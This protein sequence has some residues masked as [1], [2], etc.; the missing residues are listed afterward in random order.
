[1]F[2]DEIKGSIKDVGGAMQR[3]RSE[4]AGDTDAQVARA[5][6]DNPASDLVS[7]RLCFALVFN[8]IFAMI[9]NPHRLQVAEHGGIFA[10]SI[11]HRGDWDHE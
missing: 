7:V 10:G 2:K 1:M 3:E 6:L 4:F 5:E 9:T 8:G 11:L